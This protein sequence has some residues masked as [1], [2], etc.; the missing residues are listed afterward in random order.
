MKDK[1]KLKILY[2]ITKSNWGGAQKYVYSLAT[3]LKDNYDVVVA[4]GGGGV[5]G[6]EAPGPLKTNLETAGIRTIFI[7][8]LQRDV[9]PIREL[10]T[11]FAALWKLFRKEK[12]DI[13]HLNSSKA[14]GE[15]AFAARLVGVPKIIFT[16]HGLA[17]DEDRNII[18][19]F[20]IKFATWLTFVLCHDVVVMSQ[21]TYNRASS[22]LWCKKRVHLIYNGISNQIDFEPKEVALN[23]LGPGKPHDVA[24][25]GSI[26]E[27]TPNKRYD[28]LISAAKILTEKNIK[29]VICLIGD[30]EERQK[31][32]NLAKAENV[33]DKIIFAGNIPKFAA[34]YLKAFDI[35]VLP[36]KKEGLPYVLLEAGIAGL[37]CVGSKIP[38]I[39]DIIDDEKTGLLYDFGDSRS[40]ADRLI[41]LATDSGLKNELGNNLKQKIELKFSEEIMVANT[42]KLYNI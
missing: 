42:E 27:L 8:E 16:S 31:L 17:Y 22:L 33:S 26:G 36:S 40:L 13:V 35:F 29:F 34:K 24:W 10:Q 19:R 37:A 9:S 38:G 21:D 5:L 4:F 28:L 32:E 18:S 15:G 6:T 3:K 1:K 2:L 25:I 23:K 41:R 20:L 7:P 14:G 12:P 39:S 30:G 11:V